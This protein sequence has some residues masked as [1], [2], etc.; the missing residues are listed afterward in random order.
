V[1]FTQNR[2]M[3]YNIYRRYISCDYANPAEQ[4]KHSVDILHFAVSKRE[5]WHLRKGTDPCVFLRNAL[6]TSLTPR[7]ICFLFAPFLASLSTFLHSFSSARGL[8]MTLIADFVAISAVIWQAT[9]SPLVGH[10]GRSPF[11]NAAAVETQPGEFK[12]RVYSSA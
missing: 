10:Q 2:K 1:V 3:G 11:R 4:K 5:L 6:T 12:A 7:L 8:A 9:G